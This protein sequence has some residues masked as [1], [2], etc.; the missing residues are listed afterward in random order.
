MKAI[1]TDITRCTGCDKCKEACYN[2]YN[3]GEVSIPSVD[4]KDDL[5]DM[6]WT[7]VV[8]YNEGRVYI[9]DKEVP[10]Y[11]KEINEET[12]K[13]HPRAGFVRRHCLHCNEPTCV[14]V[15][16]VG[17]FRKDHET[18]AVIYDSG[19]CIG[20]RY[21]MYACPYGIPRYEWGKPFPIVQKCLFCYDRIK[22]GEQPACTEVCPE[23]ATLFGDRDEL[24]AEA[25]RRIEKEPGRYLNHVYGENEAGGTSVLYITKPGV[26]LD[27]IFSP[28]LGVDPLPLYTYKWVLKVPMIGLGAA[29]AL[30]GLFWVIQRRNRLAGG[31]I[32]A[33]RTETDAR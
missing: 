32:L 16:P 24:I 12:V 9:K 15:C 17:A 8:L 29:F 19:R 31:E 2:L 20:C 13:E 3:K 30:T 28:R 4:A 26:P 6:Y 18:G 23:G 10:G 21:C 11:P 25:H 33:E 1:L 27:F 7:T 14:S 22:R 5:S